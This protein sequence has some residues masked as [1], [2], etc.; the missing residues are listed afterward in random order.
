MFPLLRRNPDLFVDQRVLHRPPLC[1]IYY[2]NWY[3]DE[4]LILWLF[5]EDTDRFQIAISCFACYICHYDVIQE[6]NAPCVSSD[7]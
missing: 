2:F 5:L 1:H 3:Q 6:L 4:G 7:E